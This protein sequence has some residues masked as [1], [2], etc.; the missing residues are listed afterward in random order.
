MFSIESLGRTVWT[1]GVAPSERFK[2]YVCSA[3]DVTTNVKKMHFLR[4]PNTM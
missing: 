2:T 3:R 1:N 4:F